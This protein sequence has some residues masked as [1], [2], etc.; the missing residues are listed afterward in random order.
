MSGQAHD[1]GKPHGLAFCL[2]TCQYQGAP[3]KCRWD[4]GASGC[5]QSPS[6]PEGS[7]TSWPRWPSP[8]HGFLLA[9]YPQTEKAGLSWSSPLCLRPKHSQQVT[10]RRTHPAVGAGDTADLLRQTELQAVCGSGPQW[11]S[12]SPGSPV[13]VS[14][15][16][17]RAAVMWLCFVP[18]L[19]AYLCRHR[20]ATLTLPDSQL[21]T[22]SLSPTRPRVSCQMD[23]SCRTQRSAWCAKRR[24]KRRAG[25]ASADS[26]VGSADRVRAENVHCTGRGCWISTRYRREEFWGSRRAKA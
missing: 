24:N 4:R 7:A 3:S 22:S 11:A 20:P 8:P 16:G 23:D 6:N 21:D 5:G 1:K 10:C 17:P 15:C 9:T 12:H 13:S 25:I 19:P 14:T 18:G 26:A 2:P